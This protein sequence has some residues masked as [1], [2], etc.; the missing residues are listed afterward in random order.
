MQEKHDRQRSMWSTPRRRRLAPSRTSPSSDRCGRAGCRARRRAA[1]RSGTWRCRARNGR[2]AGGSRR[3]ARSSGSSSCAFEKFVC[4]L[5]P[6]CRTL[7]SRI[8][9]H[10]AAVENPGRIEGRLEPR[11]N[12]LDVGHRA[13]GTRRH[14]R[15]SRA[16]RGSEWHGRRVRRRRGA[17]STAPASAAAGTSSQIKPPDQS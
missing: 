3:R 15:L 2:S 10:A 17:I 9:V 1:H 12:A 11:V 8:G 6:D 5:T 4:M 13:A 14:A 7:A 16:R